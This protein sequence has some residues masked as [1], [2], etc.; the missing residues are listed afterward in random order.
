MNVYFFDTETTG[1]M[2][3]DRLCQLAVKGENVDEPIL[4]EYYNP[5]KPIPPEA[6]AVHH[7]TNKMVAD[8][9]LF[10]ESSRYAEIK[11][12]FESPDTWVVAHNSAFDVS[13]LN[14][15]DIYPTNVIC[16]YKVLKHLDGKKEFG[17]HKLQYM[18][19][20]LDMELDVPAHDALA[21]VCVLEKLFQYLRDRVMAERNASKDDAL[22]IMKEMTETPCLVVDFTFG[23][24]KGKT[25]AEVADTAPD[26]LQWLLAE[27]QKNPVGEEDWIYTLQHYLN[28]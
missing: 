14:S 3:G 17:S 19:Y 9:P 16:T 22:R 28:R 8:K 15:D 20:A 26:Y 13:M 24:Y 21:D 1:N 7:I 10:K 6:S 25:V 27:K 12:L 11:G 4:N 23:K 5:G 2:P 18:R